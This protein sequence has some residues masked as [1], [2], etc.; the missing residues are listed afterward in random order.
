M[1]ESRSTKLSFL[2]LALAVPLTA[3]AADASAPGAAPAVGEKTEQTSAPLTT[4]TYEWD[5]NLGH[6]TVM[7]PVTEGMCFITGVGGDFQGTGENV[8]IELDNGYWVLTGAS[9]QNSVTGYALCQAWS[10]LGGYGYGTEEWYATAYGGNGCGIG[11]CGSTYYPGSATLWN[12]VNF[13]SLGYISGD[14]DGNSWMQITWNG[15]DWVLN[16]YEDN[17]GSYMTAG[18]LCVG[19]KLS[20]NIDFSGI[21]TWKTGDAPVE[22]GSASDIVCALSEVQGGFRGGGEEIEIL[23]LGGTY[24]LWGKSEQPNTGAQAVC[25]YLHQS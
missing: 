2:L 5:Q 10:D 25:M 19:L 7:W 3:C 16:D 18:G 14:F 9:Q 4:A 6:V 8:H 1:F 11:A 20:H 22:L 21:Y 13:C 12:G 24:Y 15:T 23:N 17:P